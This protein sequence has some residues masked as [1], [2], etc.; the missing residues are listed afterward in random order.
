MWAHEMRLPQ[1]VQLAARNAVHLLVP[2]SFNKK[3]QY[4]SLIHR[5]ERKF[6][7]FNLYP[8]N[9]DKMVGSCQC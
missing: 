8:A 2:G 3:R 7:Y 1:L 9:V 6:V 4:F 5:E